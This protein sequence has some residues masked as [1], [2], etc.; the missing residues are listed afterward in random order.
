M[1]STSGATAKRRD[2]LHAAEPSTAALQ[3]KAKAMN[4]GLAASEPVN[5]ECSRAIGH[6]A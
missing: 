6:I 4:H 2:N 3:M 5:T 1:A